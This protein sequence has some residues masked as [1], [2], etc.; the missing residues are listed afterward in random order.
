LGL[1]QIE[2]DLG[3]LTNE[4]DDRFTGLHTR[5]PGAELYAEAIVRGLLAIDNNE[6]VTR[7]A[8]VAAA[9]LRQELHHV[10][11]VPP[12]RETVT[13]VELRLRPRVPGK[14]SFRVIQPHQV[15]PFSP[16]LAVVVREPGTH[17]DSLRSL[18]DPYCYFD[19]QTYA[20]LDDRTVE[21]GGICTLSIQASAEDP[22]YGSSRR[23]LE[24][25]PDATHRRI[26]PAGPIKVFSTV[27]LAVEL[28]RYE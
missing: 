8:M 28:L 4:A 3:P 27:P 24:R 5:L 6:E 9:T 11:L 7:R 1:P 14:Y 17:G 18:W 25:W 20:V 13:S 10:K 19:R 2:I 22:H 15:G 21:E 26:R 16:M 23:P 12:A